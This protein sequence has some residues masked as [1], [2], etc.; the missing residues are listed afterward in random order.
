[1]VLLR[2]QIWATRNRW[3]QI[4]CHHPP[5][6]PGTG[7]LSLPPQTTQTRIGWISRDWATSNHS[8]MTKRPIPLRPK[9]AACGAL[10]IGRILPEVPYPLS[11]GHF[12]E[13]IDGVGDASTTVVFIHADILAV[14]CPSIIGKVRCSNHLFAMKHDYNKWPEN[15]LTHAILKNIATFSQPL[16]Q[17]MRVLLDQ[18]IP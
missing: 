13:N 14:S 17:S 16:E 6:H 5:A 9:R 11:I 7:L 12:S 2:E 1:M 15:T 3:K 18:R 8:W 10:A 4:A